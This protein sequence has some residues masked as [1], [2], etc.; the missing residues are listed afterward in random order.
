MKRFIILMLGLTWAISSYAQKTLTDTGPNNV[1]GQNTFTLIPMGLVSNLSGG[2]ALTA[3]TRYYDSI[4]ADRTITISAPT[5]PVTVFLELYVTGNPNLIFGTGFTN[6]IR[7]GDVNSTISSFSLQPGAQWVRLTYDVAT[8]TWLMTDSTVNIVT[9]V[10]G[11]GNNVESWLTNPT[12]TNLNSALDT[13]V[14]GLNAINAFTG[15]NSFS[16]SPN[17][18]WTSAATGSHTASLNNQYYIASFTTNTTIS[19]YVGTP[20]NGSKVAFLLLGCNGTATFGFPTA[21]RSGDPTGTS[22]SITPTAG[23]HMFVFTFINSN[24]YYQDDVT[25]V[26]G[27]NTQVLFNSSGSVTGSAN[28]TWNDS[29]KVMT[30]GSTSATIASASTTL[31]V[32]GNPLRLQAE[33]TGSVQLETGGS[34]RFAIDNTG[35]FLIAGS[36]GTSGQ[37]I[38]SV[39]SG[40][41]AI[42]GNDVGC[43]VFNVGDGSTTVT[44]GEK[45]TA[46][47]TIPFSCTLTGWT[48]LADASTTTTIDVWKDTYANYPAT[49]AD[50]ITNGHSPATSAAN[51]A[52]QTNIT[53]WSTTAVTAGDQMGFS[54]NANNNAHWVQLIITYTRP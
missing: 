46:R 52:T 30:I 24:W 1:K 20:V 23:T 51:K 54:V 32:Q 25:S 53:N 13:P 39:G 43:I 3:N 10:T 4:S 42:W 9:Q 41:P 44:T 49:G 15:L 28:F 7:L 37:V 5:T 11:L 38:T 12:F 16:L 18:G 50:I 47:L 45:V 6:V 21:Q 22:S 36:A 31:F 14:A 19:S 33:S 34:T 40:Q 8:S 2:T 26:P 48:I 27:S 17:I 35:A 29:T